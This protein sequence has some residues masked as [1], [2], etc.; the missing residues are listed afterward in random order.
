MILVFWHVT[1]VIEE[2]AIHLLDIA[3]MIFTE[4]DIIECI[5]HTT[6]VEVVFL[7]IDIEADALARS[8]FLFGSS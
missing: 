8:A 4:E 6:I 2:I 3:D 1:I 5:L 7:V